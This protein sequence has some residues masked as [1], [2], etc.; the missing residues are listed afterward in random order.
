MFGSSVDR[1]ATNS[2][3]NKLDAFQFTSLGSYHISDALLRSPDDGATLDLTKQ[4][5]T[6]VGESGAEELATIG[7][8]EDEDESIVTRVALSHNQLTTLP[9]AFALLSRLRYLNLR[10]NSFTV[11]PDVLTMMPSLDTLDISHNKLRSLPSKPG[12]L[13][14]LRVLCLSRN[15]LRRLPTYLS[16]FEHLE[17]FQVDRNPIEWPPKSVLLPIGGV[18]TPESMREW[19]KGLRS[20]LSED[21]RTNKGYDRSGSALDH[22]LAESYD[23]WSRLPLSE[24][25][26]DA[27]LTPH[28][29]SFSI[30]S[31]FTMSSTSE[32]FQEIE[33]PSLTNS[34]VMDQPPPLHLGILQSYST[35]TSPMHS[36]DTYLPS[37]ADSDFGV[38]LNGLVSPPE[39][40][41]NNT[42]LVEE[43]SPSSPPQHTRNSSFASAGP[44]N[45]RSDLLSKQSM[46]DLRTAKLTF[47]K[48]RPELPERPG[49]PSNQKT[50]EFFMPSPLSMR[51]DSNSS[52]SSNPRIVAS[53]G[54]ESKDSSPA[55]PA[56]PTMAFERNSYF[57]R[58]ST[59]P[60]L[61]LATTLPKPLM[62]L[63][64]SARSI[65]FA[66][67]QVYLALEH[68][69]VQAADDRLSN[70]LRKVLDPANSDMM[71]LINSLDRFDAMSR[72]VQPPASV[73]RALVEGC[74]DTVSV[75]GKAIGVLSLQ[76]KMLGN[77]DVRYLRSLLLVLYGAT[78]EISCAWQ[79][80]TPH[81]EAIKPLLHAK[82]PPAPMNHLATFNSADAHP[83]SAP[84]GST[85]LPYYM[86]S[87]ASAHSA[88]RSNPSV[89]R[90]ARRHAGSF[91][92]KDVEIGKTLPSYEDM[93][94]VGGGVVPG[95]A[96]PVP[97][98]RKAKRQ[99]TLPLTSVVISSPSPTNPP[100]SAGP[101]VPAFLTEV[102]HPNH[103][104][105]GSQ[106]SQYGSPISS[107]PSVS[108]PRVSGVEP[109][110][111]SSS[112]QQVDKQALQA[113][114]EAVGVAPAVWEMMDSALAD[115]LRTDAEVRESLERAKAVTN[116]LT[117][118]I[119]TIVDGDAR[120]DKKVLW[121]DGH[122]FL[123]TVV[124]LSNVIKTH[125]GAS[126]ALRSNMVKLTNAT[127]EFA[128]LFHVSSFS[129]SV[130]ARAY[131]PML[132]AHPSTSSQASLRSNGA[133]ASAPP[134]ESRLGSSLSRSRS[135]QPV[136]ST[137]RLLVE[138][139]R[140]ALPSQSFKIPIVRRRDRH[141]AIPVGGVASR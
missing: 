99:P 88:L 107:S 121:E 53:M 32:S 10:S 23:S 46:P 138:P 2:P 22:E 21:P 103:S 125:G 37:P 62:C 51:Q 77:E 5:L 128:I 8:N 45:T 71:Q 100:A 97:I 133:P 93:P 136:P 60:T 87:P 11:F 80:M 19:I 79:A 24:S 57:R 41:L 6:E 89:I 68:Y 98:L 117:T 44:V 47:H 106:T 120:A 112:K 122:V 50:D 135:A 137:R 116:R 20:W 104:R 17:I 35:E 92:S 13:P 83:A 70:V 48:K 29:R 1:V 102:I 16:W 131:S 84:V 86:D 27:G 66:V 25:E 74:K 127:E 105:H 64:D 111:A 132:S 130:P 126:S 108:V 141:E 119:R 7:R 39:P 61:N 72:K 40:E 28:A 56:V 115:V 140:S 34:I 123:K 139:P 129:P 109:P 75:F 12:S 58:L 67:C 134:E 18:E 113:M 65:L 9:R 3:F 31:N 33:P 15:K 63:V 43:E 14:N 94:S 95:S 55:R 85:S 101:T 49:P 82:P 38:R 118:T 42:T 124:Q 73:C 36:P 26:F 91:S 4:N 78:A 96:P 59:L 52:L 114:R 76:L 110:L 69:T 54:R 30:G 81:L 90:T